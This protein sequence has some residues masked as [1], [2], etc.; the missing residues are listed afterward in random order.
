M[1]STDL[2]WRTA[3][4][5]SNGGGECVEIGEAQRGVLVR[6]TKERDGAILRFSPRAW[7]RFI[8]R[9][10]CSLADP[11][12]CVPRGTLAS[13]VHFCDWRAAGRVYRAYSASAGTRLRGLR[14]F[15]C[16]DQGS[17]KPNI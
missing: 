17:R 13:W 11:Q 14:R 16:V 7:R 6:D 2:N 5:S 4:Y 10:K 12:P 15:Y 8:D 1:E 3:S 9:V